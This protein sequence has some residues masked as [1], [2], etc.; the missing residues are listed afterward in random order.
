ARGCD[1]PQAAPADPRL[2]DR[3]GRADRPR[4]RKTAGEGLHLGPAKPPSQRRRLQPLGRELPAR[5]PA[6]PPQE[7]DIAARLSTPPSPH[8]QAHWPGPARSKVRTRARQASSKHTP[9][10]IR[11][12]HRPSQ[13]PMTPQ[14]APKAR[15]AATGSPRPQKA[16][17][18]NAN[19]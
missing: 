2:A 18:L 11:P 9:S 13:R 5:T 3:Q 14:P 8:S 19:G 6:D 16:R 15:P 7:S 10:T 17:I 4:H 1:P 12:V